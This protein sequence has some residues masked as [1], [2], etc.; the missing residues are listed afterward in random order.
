MNYIFYYKVICIAAGVII[1][2][3]GYRLFVK[4]IFSASGD[5]EGRWKDLKLIVRKA[6]PGTYFVLFG[7]AIIG[8]TVHQG[9]S[10]EEKEAAKSSPPAITAPKTDST[11][12]FNMDTSKFFHH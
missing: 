1:I 10:M 5:V 7:S 8:F 4:G 3:L 9:F 12:I 2:S 6:A 11:A